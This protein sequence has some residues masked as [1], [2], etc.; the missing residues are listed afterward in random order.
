MILLQSEVYRS[1]N[2]AAVQRQTYFLCQACLPV[3]Y[4]VFCDEDSGGQP[5]S[6]QMDVLHHEFSESMFCWH[7]MWLRRCTSSCCVLVEFASILI[8]NNP[9]KRIFKLRKDM[10]ISS[11]I[12]LKRKN[13]HLSQFSI[14]IIDLLFLK[15]RFR[16]RINLELTRK[17]NCLKLHINP[18]ERS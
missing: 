15:L 5:N 17:L 8:K 3:A 6:F 9:P 2:R 10:K 4:T 16:I 14:L 18:K 11:I 13:V 1:S 7:I 12:L